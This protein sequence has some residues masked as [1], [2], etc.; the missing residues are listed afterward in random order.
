MTWLWPWVS[1][2]DMV[3]ALVRQQL[4]SEAR[5]ADLKSSH[6]HIL[7]ALDRQIG[8]ICEE[9]DAMA[10]RYHALKLQ[11]ASEPEPPRVVERTVVDPVIAAVNIACVGKEQARKGMLVQV[12]RD[13]E[14]ELSDQDIILRIQRGNRPQEEVA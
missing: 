14:A 3:A 10:L 12:A 11:G 2:G 13:R 5:I 7:D 4:S 6:A 1:R 9:R 8:R